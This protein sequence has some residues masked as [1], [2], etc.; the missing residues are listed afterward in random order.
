MDPL[1]LEE[2]RAA[3]EN[4]RGRAVRTPLVRLNVDPETVNGVEIF[5]KV[6]TLQPVGSFKIRGALHACL[7]A[8][9]KLLQQGVWTASAG[10]MAQGV[11]WA[12]RLLGAKCSVAVPDNAP[13]GKVAAIRALGAEVIYVPRFEWFEFVIRGVPQSWMLN[14]LFI[15]PCSHREVMAGQG[16]IGLEI[17]ED[18][19]SANVVITPYGGGGLTGGVASAV[20]LLSP[21][22]RC[23]ACELETGAPLAPSLAAGAPVDIIPTHAHA[24]AEGFSGSPTIIAELWPVMKQN[25]CGSAIVSVA[26]LAAAVRLLVTRQHIVAEGAGAAALAA[27]MDGKVGAKPGDKVVC[28]VSGGHIDTGVL[29]EIL[30]GVDTWDLN[31]RPVSGDGASWE[32]RLRLAWSAARKWGDRLHLSPAGVAFTP[33][34]VGLGAGVGLGRMLGM[35]SA[36]A[37]M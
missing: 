31:D 37:R 22:C 11:A 36:M 9:P 29:G 24:F 33:V 12:A 13:Q 21:E 8:D 35:R 27:V 15:H 3:A 7:S 20:K 14:G 16:T 25:L 17:L 28:V 5:L 26:E 6:E 10:N 4:I 1:R 19:P 32:L 2:F 30:D 18:L 34:L 23:W